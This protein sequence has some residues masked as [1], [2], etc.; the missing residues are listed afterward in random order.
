MGGPPT[1]AFATRAVNGQHGG[2][3]IGCAEARPPANEVASVHCSRAFAPQIRWRVMSVPAA[4][5]FPKAP[6]CRRK[7]LP[8]LRQREGGIQAK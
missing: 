2:N 5:A 4:R 3:R 6:R 8:D 1:A 7:R